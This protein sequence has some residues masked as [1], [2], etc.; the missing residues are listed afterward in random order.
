MFHGKSI[1]ELKDQLFLTESAF[2]D[3]DDDGLF[4]F[5]VI[6]QF[7]VVFVRFLVRILPC[8]DCQCPLILIETP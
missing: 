7:Q 4:I 8:C 3:D 5:W 2:F 6:H 1:P